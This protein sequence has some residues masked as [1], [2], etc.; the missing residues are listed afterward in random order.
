MTAPVHVETEPAWG[1]AESLFQPRRAAFWLFAGL[2]VFGVIRLLSF[3]S[4]LIGDAPDAATLAL[5]L[6]ALYAI[7]F[8][9][10]IRRLD[11]LE[12]EPAPFLGAALLWGGVVATSLA[13]IANHAVESI[14]FKAA[15]VHFALDWQAAIAGPSDEE[16]LKALGI[17]VVV[18]IARRQVNTLLDGLVYGAFVGLGFQIVEDFLYSLQYA[19]HAVSAGAST[20]EAVW[21][22]FVIRGFAGGLWSH[23]V[24]TGIVGVG[25]AYFVLR[26]DRT[27]QRRLA[28]AGGLFAA[29]W[30]FHFFWNSPWL[31]EVVT[32]DIYEQYTVIALIKGLPALLLLLVLYR[33]AHR[34]EVA[35]FDDALAGEGVL[36]TPEE[37]AALHTRKGRLAESKAE[38]RRTGPRGARLRRQ[39]QQAQVRLAA[40]NVRAGDPR[41]PAVEEARADVRAAR[42]ALA[43]VPP[44]PVA[45]A[46]APP[47]PTDPAGKR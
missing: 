11:L 32:G 18:L 15:G 36:V 5:V 4:G 8:V 13:L 27:L 44:A 7:P 19:Q 43:T 29:A 16:V 28:V 2:F 34:R 24:Y 47:A 31:N 12:P 41:A 21:H 23:A 22:I 38:Q 42:E 37:L 9:L 17:V 39:L 14:V 25:I 40:A 20:N 30:V 45:P 1:Q 33:L 10:V 46:T 35:W 3:V 6:W 26:T